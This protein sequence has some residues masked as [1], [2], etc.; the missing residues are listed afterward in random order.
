MS[1]SEPDAAVWKLIYLAR[2][3][4]ALRPEDFSQAWREHSALGRQCLNVGRRVVAVAQCSR[5]LQA[6]APALSHEHDGVNLMVLADRDAGAAIWSD[7]ETLAVMRPDEPR[8]FADYVRNFSMLCRQR[9]LHSRLP[10]AALPQKGQVIL[11]GF[12]QRSDAWRGAA[13]APQTCPAQWRQGVLDLAAR[14]VCNTLEEQAPRGYGF[15]YIVEWWFDGREQAMAAAQALGEAD[16][17]G[18]YGWGDSIFMLTEVTH[19]RP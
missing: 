16:A 5:W 8:V 17:G 13:S 6:C 4:P 12:L 15:R 2:R 19:S 9:L 3:N 14:I 11:L 18:E 1:Q 10:A 7:P